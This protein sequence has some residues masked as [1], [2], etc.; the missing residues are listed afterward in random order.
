VPGA[1]RKSLVNNEENELYHDSANQLVYHSTA[2]ASTSP[3]P[4]TPVLL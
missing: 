1:A 3:I 4:I 2:S